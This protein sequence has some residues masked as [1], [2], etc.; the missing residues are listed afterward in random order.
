MIQISVKPFRAGLVS[1]S[2]SVAKTG[3]MPILSAVLCRVENG[4]MTLKTTNLETT[5][6]YSVEDVESSG[7]VTFAVEHAQLLQ[8]LNAIERETITLGYSEDTLTITCTGVNITLGTLNPDDFPMMSEVAEDVVSLNS[9]ILIDTLSRAITTV[10][11]ETT[12]PTLA[13][14]AISKNH[15]KV[16]VASSDGFRMTIIEFTSDWNPLSIIL[17]TQNVNELLR[18][19]KE[20]DTVGVCLTDRSMLAVVETNHQR[21]QGRLIDGKY[22]NVGAIIDRTM[23]F[24]TTTINTQSLL[25]A[26]RLVKLYVDKNA[27]RAEL[28]IHQML[29]GMWVLTISATS[30]KGTITQDVEVVETSRNDTATIG[31]NITYLETA[32]RGVSA[33]NTVLAIGGSGESIDPFIIRDKTETYTYQHVIM[34]MTRK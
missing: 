7:D 9:Q 14:V 15:D 17:P 16:M 31:V 25:A 11:T 26:I 5:A 21:V 34:P 10:A 33:S 12:R 6:S 28:K 3:T 27:P 18:L 24:P 20:N 4:T 13:G 29:P 30:D 23:S 32:I 1:V 19:A 8:T 2:K 22:P